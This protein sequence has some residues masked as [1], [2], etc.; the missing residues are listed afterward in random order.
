MKGAILPMSHFAISSH[1]KNDHLDYEIPTAICL[2]DKAGMDISMGEESTTHMASTD[3]FPSSD[4]LMDYLWRATNPPVTSPS[5]GS[6]IKDTQTTISRDDRK[7]AAA[8]QS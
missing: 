7:P 6:A 8:K 5:P 4:E 1:I 2:D 3:F